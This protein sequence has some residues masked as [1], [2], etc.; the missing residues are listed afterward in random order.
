MNFHKLDIKSL[1][2]EDL[3]KVHKTLDAMIKHRQSKKNHPKLLKKKFK[4]DLN[5]SEN[6]FLNTLFSQ[7][8]LE[9]KARNL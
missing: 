2:N 6:G 9:L 5:N 7:I 1:S 8:N 3:Q 4:I